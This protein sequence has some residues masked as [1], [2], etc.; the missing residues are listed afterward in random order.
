MTYNTEELNI[1]ISNRRTIWPEQYDTTLTIDDSLVRQ[2]L[3]N[4]NWA[5]THGNTEPWRFKVY[6][7]QALKHLA[8]LQERIFRDTTPEDSFR[9]D[10]LD[11][12]LMRTLAS[13]HVIAI[14]MTPDPKGKILELEEI[15][16]V[17]CAAQNMQLTATA[18]GVGAFWSTGG[19][20]YKPGV[21]DYFNLKTEDKLLGF[22]MLGYPAI[23]WPNGRR[24]PIEDKVQWYS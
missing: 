7:G 13:S 23:K 21:N 22:L 24:K 19:I 18:H 6:T 1:L 14:I 10:K 4:A 9:Q 11:K 16:A 8:E 17:A 3:E 20:T 5:P 15:E 2:M 12:M